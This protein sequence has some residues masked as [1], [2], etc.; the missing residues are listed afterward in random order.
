MK[1]YKRKFGQYKVE[2]IANNICIVGNTNSNFGIFYNFL[3]RFEA[4]KKHPLG[5]DNDWNRPQVIAMDSEY[6]LTQ[7]VKEWLYNLVKKDKIETKEV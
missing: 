2:V 1:I 3:D 4:F 5:K 6:G 7:S